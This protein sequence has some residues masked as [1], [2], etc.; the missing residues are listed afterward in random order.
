MRKW[1]YKVEKMPHGIKHTILVDELIQDKLNE[2]GMQG[3]ELV[4][5]IVPNM[6]LGGSSEISLLMKREIG[7]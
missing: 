1:E 5:T 2:L 6:V 4:S 3:W 7:Q